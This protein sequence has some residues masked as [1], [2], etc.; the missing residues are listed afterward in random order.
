MEIRGSRGLAI[1]GLVMVGAGAG[2]ML[3]LHAYAGLDPVH[4]VISEYAYAPG[5]WLLPASLTLFA[6]GAALLS[7]ALARVGE[8]R[9]IVMLVA[10]WGACILLVGAFPT[11]RPGVP[12]SMSG[13]IHR[14]AAFVA[15]LVVPPAG[16]L[17][18]RRLGRCGRA[19][20]LKVLSVVAGVA[21]IAVV[22]PYVL[23]MGGIPV[24]DEDVPAG[25]TQRIVVAAELGVLTLL[26]LI[27][28][29]PSGARAEAE[30]SGA[31]AA[32]VSGAGS[33]PLRAWAT[34]A[35]PVA[36]S[37][38]TRREFER[39]SGFTGASAGL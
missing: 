17:L 25:V 2:G 12:L 9:R 18:A 28:A 10:L 24:A 20:L 16:L 27:V 38:V 26:G 5:G 13:G 6:V 1:G 19:T 11:D 35:H 22:V 34:T 14:Y 8:D 7:A 33:A 37:A 21:L 15:F 23:R 32:R 29:R 36:R 3:L 30:T 39:D 4:S 31:A